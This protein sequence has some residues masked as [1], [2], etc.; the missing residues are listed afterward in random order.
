MTKN[1]L[2]LDSWEERA[3]WQVGRVEKQRK[4]ALR[5]SREASNWDQSVSIES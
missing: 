4:R 3:R 1:Q 2:L 5:S